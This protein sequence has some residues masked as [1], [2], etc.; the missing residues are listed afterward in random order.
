M[1]KKAVLDA[2]DLYVKIVESKKRHRISV[3]SFNGV[4][5]ADLL[6]YYLNL[7]NDKQAEEL[8]TA[9]LNKNKQEILT[10]LLLINNSTMLSKS[11]GNINYPDVKKFQNELQKHAA[12]LC[13]GE[14]KQ[15]SLRTMVAHANN[16]HS[17]VAD[18]TPVAEVTNQE[19][20]KNFLQDTIN[21]KL[22]DNNKLIRKKESKD[23][24]KSAHEVQVCTLE[25]QDNL[26]FVKMFDSSKDLDQQAR[27]AI[28]EATYALLWMTLAKLAGNNAIV[29]E[30]ALVIDDKKNIIG[31]ASIG[32]KGFESLYRMLDNNE[33]FGRLVGLLTIL[34][35]TPLLKEQDLHIHN[36]GKSSIENIGIVST[37]N[38]K[39]ISKIDHDMII[40]NWDKLSKI[41]ETANMNHLAEALATGSL[42]KFINTLETVRFSPVTINSRILQTGH[43]ARSK[44]TDRS[45]TTVSKEDQAR[46]LS[47]L[48][49]IGTNEEFQMLFKAF[50]NFEMVSENLFAFKK[51][52]DNAFSNEGFNDQ[53]CSKAYE[54]FHHM[55][56][57][58]VNFSQKVQLF[59]Q[60]YQYDTNVVY[61]KFHQ[62]KDLIEDTLKQR[63][64]LITSITKQI[65]EDCISNMSL[66]QNTEF[67][68]LKL[69]QTLLGELIK[70]EITFAQAQQLVEVT[71]FSCSQL[72]SINLKVV[73]Y[74]QVSLSNSS[75]SNHVS[76]SP[77]PY[78]HEIEH[79]NDSNKKGVT[80][81]DTNSF[82]Q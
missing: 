72:E 77:K 81:E 43:Y 42:S 30:T 55:F 59:S 71:K 17:N 34:L 78:F 52:I 25:G 75:S 31:V 27:D 8:V 60:V 70:P 9:Y 45:D 6:K 68:K 10:Q 29:S 26:Y 66:H 69:T 20:V 80:S 14:D 65:G 11:A 5:R 16:T 76:T 24:A 38:I 33:N 51:H 1:N 47:E 28:A 39:N 61:N 3:N 23:A 50:Q 56:L 15:S 63:N 79:N 22:I 44:L 48:S 73:D 57:R 49:T 18:T 13:K 62:N 2:I 53:Q 37:E 7:A 12:D 19:D 54:I 58:V 41:E 67:Q 40:A 82:N 46:V 35:L 36:I 32:L 64:K 21:I 74:S 4:D